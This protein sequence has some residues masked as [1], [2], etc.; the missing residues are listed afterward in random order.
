MFLTFGDYAPDCS[1]SHM[2]LYGSLAYTC[3]VDEGLVLNIYDIHCTCI[4][5][6]Y[7]L[8]PLPCKWLICPS[9]TLQVTKSATENDPIFFF[10]NLL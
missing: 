7:R 8:Y 2:D 3:I 10:L 6:P 1:Q 5:F 4:E 9:T